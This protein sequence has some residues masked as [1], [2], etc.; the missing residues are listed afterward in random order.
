MT[1][2]TYDNQTGLLL[3]EGSIYI[4]ISHLHWMRLTH[5]RKPICFAQSTNL[6]VI[7]MVKKQG[8]GH[9]IFVQHM[10]QVDRN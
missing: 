5:S 7:L 9:D 6:N 4:F 8:H 1:I 2:P 10:V 3:P